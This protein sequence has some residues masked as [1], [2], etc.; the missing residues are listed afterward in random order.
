MTKKELTN[1]N[2]ALQDSVD[3]LKD[4]LKDM[5]E[6]LF[7]DKFSAAAREI[8]MEDRLL[9]TAEQLDDDYCEWLTSVGG[10]DELRDL[11]QSRKGELKKESEDPPTYTMEEIL[12]SLEE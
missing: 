5:Q 1:F 4:K 11:V 7:W 8:F 2:N 10:P 9:I 6:D 3:L 12:K